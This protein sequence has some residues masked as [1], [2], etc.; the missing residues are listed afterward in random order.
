MR[1]KRALMR[2]VPQGRFRARDSEIPDR[3]AGCPE[4]RGAGAAIGRTGF[5]GAERN[6][7]P[8]DASTRR[9]ERLALGNRRAM[10]MDA[11]A[12]TKARRVRPGPRRPNAAPWAG[13]PPPASPPPGWRRSSP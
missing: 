2:G 5:A 12:R 11:P 10:L 9:Y 6:P 3:F 4:G 13:T 1:R 7:L 8:G